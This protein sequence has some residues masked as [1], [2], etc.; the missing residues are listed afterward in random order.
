[1][2]KSSEDYQ[3]STHSRSKRINKQQTFIQ[4]SVPLKMAKQEKMH[5]NLTSTS[6]KKENDQEGLTET[7][8]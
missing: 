2:L 4:K 6:Q 1:M 8:N 3:L 7:S 5:S